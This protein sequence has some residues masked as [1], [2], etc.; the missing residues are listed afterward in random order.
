ML[1]Q[2]VKVADTGLTILRI[3]LG[4]DMVVDALSTVASGISDEQLESIVAGMSVH[5]CAC[6]IIPIST[7]KKRY[8]IY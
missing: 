5:L 7:P 4:A 1:G 8:I 6:E 3:A 2:P